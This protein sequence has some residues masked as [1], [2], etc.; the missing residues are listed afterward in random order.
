MQWV[1]CLRVALLGWVLG[2]PLL[3]GCGGAVEVPQVDEK[4]AEQKRQDYEEMI[5]KERANQ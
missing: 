1:R 5:K 4:T 2:F 3:M